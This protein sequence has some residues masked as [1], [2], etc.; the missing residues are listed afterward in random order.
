MSESA[1]SRL[2]M[3][4]QCIGDRKGLTALRAFLDKIEKC[5]S[6]LDRKLNLAEVLEDPANQKSLANYWGRDGIEVGNQ[7]ILK[8]ALG[9]YRVQSFAIRQDIAEKN[10]IDSI[11]H[12]LSGWQ[13]FDCV[14]VFLQTGEG[15]H[16][17]TLLNPQ[18]SG[19]WRKIESISAGTLVTA[20][21]KS[22]SAKRNHA[23][24]ELAMARLRAAFALAE[25][26]EA[27]PEPKISPV[28]PIK[29]S[30]REPAKT[31]PSPTMRNAVRPA[32]TLPVSHFARPDR[33]RSQVGGE[34]A[35]SFEMV[36]SKMDTF[37]HAGN[38]QLIVGHLAGYAGRVEMFVMRGHKDPVRMDTDSI[39]GKEIRNGE[40]VL[41]EFYGPKPTED[42]VKQLYVKTNKYT[43]MDKIANE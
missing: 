39:W 42:F 6:A 20:Y 7:L 9:D 3:I 25:S 35:L 27:I 5:C 29:S 12:A 33:A 36:I 1:L 23:Q 30:P 21:L 11:T 26:H 32:P 8:I 40:K 17:I 41:F 37:I 13:Q 4:D 10:R 43:Q 22:N 38:A 15:S 2:R 14:L 19:H 18:N 31:Q 24:E 16:S 28:H 34:I